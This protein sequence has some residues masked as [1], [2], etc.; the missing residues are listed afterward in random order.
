VNYPATVSNSCAGQPTCSKP[1][2]HG[3]AVNAERAGDFS[4]RHV[5]VLKVTHRAVM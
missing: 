3:S 5:V 2:V 4:G 1:S